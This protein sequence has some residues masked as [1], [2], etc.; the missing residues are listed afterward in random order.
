MSKLPHLCLVAYLALGAWFAAAILRTYEP[1]TGFTSLISFGDH[2]EARR[3]EAL[4]GVPI[5]TLRA[6]D[7][8][9]G[10]FY[11]QLAVAGNPF[12][13]G[14][15]QA[16]DSPAYRSRRILLPLVVHLL[17]FGRAAWI[18]QLYALAN[19]ACWLMLAALCARWW[20]PPTGLHNLL[21]WIGV[22]FGAGLVASVTHSLTDGPALLVLA[23]GVR[24]H[25]RERPGAAAVLVG[26]AGLVRETSVLA[27]AIFLPAGPDNRR[28]WAR[29]AAAILVAAGPAL[30]W[31]AL[32]Q[33]HEGQVGGARN[34]SLPFAGL[35]GKLGELD[36]ARA[37]HGLPS[38]LQDAITVGALAV[39]AVAL[40]ARPRPR[41][42]W[43]RIG[44]AFALLGVCLGSAV[45]EG[46]PPA[47]ARAL[48]PMTLAFNLLTPRTRAGLA[49]LLAGNLSIVSVPSLL[50]QVPSDTLRLTH[51][52]RI[53]YRRGWYERESL[54]GRSWRWTSPGA[55]LVLVND[56]AAPRAVTLSFGAR[57]PDARTVVFETPRL[58]RTVPLPAGQIVPVQ[59]GPLEA[60]PGETTLRIT[61]PDPPWPEPGPAGGRSLVVSLYDLSGTVRF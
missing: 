58:T 28:G 4:K 31:A 39:Q 42:A 7:G 52:V 20:F 27:A 10:Q 36:R 5:R 47:A 21:R 40:L 53:E 8:Y 32:L 17:G 56:A 26:L 49:L 55:A 33:R 29:R 16:L 23:L 14:V 19:L 22:L 30:V 54:G 35:A 38:V 6:S 2:F 60:A 18:L 57:S 59:F 43:W 34:L 11:A 1:R 25:E 37:Q 13:P 24:A 44:A 46:T 61:S 51:D 50:A 41:L 48:L 15:R 3:L 45:W 9:D 12:A